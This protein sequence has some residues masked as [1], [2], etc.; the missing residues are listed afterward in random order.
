MKYWLGI[1][2]SFVYQY[3]WIEAKGGILAEKKS[4]SHFEGWFGKF[5]F[6]LI[7]SLNLIPV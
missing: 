4:I 3:G 6:Y 2:V 5:F 1:T 7:I